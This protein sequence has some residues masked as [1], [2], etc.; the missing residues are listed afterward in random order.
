M[1]QDRLRREHPHEP[2][3]PR[4][5]CRTAEQHLCAALPEGC[6]RGDRGGDWRRYR[7]GT[8]GMGRVPALSAALGRRLTKLMGRDGRLAEGRS[9]LRTQRLCLLEPRRSGLPFHP[10]FHELTPRRAGVRALDAVRR[11]LL[12]HPLPRYLQAGAVAL[13]LDRPHHQALVAVALL[14]AAVYHGAGRE[15]DAYGMAYVTRPAHAPSARPHVLAYR[16]RI[17]LWRLVPGM[18]CDE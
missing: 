4:Y 6:L 17:L 15:V 2:Q 18:P 7:V 8:G 10:R 12:P 9:S 14:P 13:S 3:L 1:Y 11:V 16:R 5:D